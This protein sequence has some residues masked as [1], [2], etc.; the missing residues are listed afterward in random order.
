MLPRSSLI[1]GAYGSLGFGIL[2]FVV[3]WKTQ[4][5]QAHDVSLFSVLD[6]TVEKLNAWRTLTPSENI[7]LPY[8][9]V[10]LNIESNA[11]DRVR[12][13]LKSK[14]DS[15]YASPFVL[16]ATLVKD[17]DHILRVVHHELKGPK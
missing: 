12:V 14:A 16:E 3:A 2:F 17:E 15:P 7:Y 9:D 10:F 8:F 4:P 11:I 13:T 1:K 5:M 6:A